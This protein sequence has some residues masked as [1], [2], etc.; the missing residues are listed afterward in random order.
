MT[1]WG[2]VCAKTKSD[3]VVMS[4]AGRIFAFFCCEPDHEPQNSGCS[5]TAQ[6]FHTARVKSTYYRSAILI[7]AWPPS[8]D[9]MQAKPY[10]LRCSIPKRTNQPNP[11]EPTVRM[12]ESLAHVHALFLSPRPP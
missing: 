10:N 11:V 3:L 12:G 1:A 9:I 8:A 4:S 6:R 5:H 2:L 7:A